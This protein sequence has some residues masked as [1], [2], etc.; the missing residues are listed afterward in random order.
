MAR[1]WTTT[2]WWVWLI[3]A[4]GVA[5]GVPELWAL[6]DGNPDTQPL[7]DFTIEQGF[8]ELAVAISAWLFIHFGGRKVADVTR[9]AET[10]QATISGLLGAVLVIYGVTK[11]GFD[12]EALSNPE[13]VGALTVVVGFAS[14]VTTWFT[15]RQQRAG[16]LQSA[17]DGTVQ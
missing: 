5:F 8:A 3:V 10:V 4:I 16:E 9:P 15:A 7:T 6:A 14:S 1:S 13:V 12:F 11:N 2:Y 17:P